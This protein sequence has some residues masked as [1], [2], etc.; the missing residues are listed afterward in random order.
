M[1][2]IYVTNYLLNGLWLRTPNRY[3]SLASAKAFCHRLTVCDKYS[4]YGIRRPDFRGEPP[5][6]LDIDATLMFS[7][8]GI[9]YGQ[10]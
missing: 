9:Y 1:Y 8:R 2:E 3:K 6:F 4:A 5:L 7:Q 10:R